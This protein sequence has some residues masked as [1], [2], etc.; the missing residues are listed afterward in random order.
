[1]TRSEFEERFRAFLRGRRLQQPHW[2]QLIEGHECDCVW[3][4]ARL[5]A[6]LDGRA[7]HDT[8]RAFERDRARDRAL[9]LAG[10]RI[11]RVTWRQLHVGTEGLARDL[12]TLIGGYSHSR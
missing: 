12:T 4:T 3:P 8:D 7:F 5:I 10:W 1:V 11:I 6:E 9:L 2:N